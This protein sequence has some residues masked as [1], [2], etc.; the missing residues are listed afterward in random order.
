MKKAG[1][2]HAALADQRKA[3]I[4]QIVI[5]IHHQHA[6]K[7]D[8]ASQAFG[9]VQAV[10][11]IDEMRQQHTEKRDRAVEHRTLYTRRVGQPQ[12]KEHEHDRRLQQPE[13]SDLEPVLATEAEDVLP[14]Q[15]GNAEQNHTREHGAPAGKDKLAGHIAG[16]DG[17]HG[18]A[19]LDGRIGTA[20]QQ[21]T[22]RRQHE[23]D[24]AVGEEVVV[25]QHAACHVRK[26]RSGERQK[27]KAYRATGWSS[28]IRRRKGLSAVV[29]IQS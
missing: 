21:T 6:A 25:I 14:R 8:Q 10:V 20:P 24:L 26:N 11:V 22:H 27:K 3:E 13:R 16:L 17:E 2:D 12:I 28:L 18:E 7:A 15:H 29:I 23:D 5:E 4:E 1:H 9:P 19:V